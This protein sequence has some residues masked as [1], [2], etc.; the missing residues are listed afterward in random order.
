MRALRGLLNAGIA[1]AALFGPATAT[2]QPV[3]SGR[4]EV[5]PAPAA[6]TRHHAPPA[7][8][9]GAPPAAPPGAPPAATPPETHDA[10]QAPAQAQP[11]GH[12]AAP[13]RD[14]SLHGDK[15]TVRVTDVQ[16]EE[17]L[18]A[19][20]APSNAEIKGTVKESRTITIDFA[21]VP[22]QDGLGR[23]LGDQNFVLTY[24]EGGAL[25][26]ITLLGTP[27][28]ESAEARIVKNA[29]GTTTTTQPSLSPGEIMQRSVPIS[30]KL[31]Q[32]LGQPT[33]TMQQLMDISIHEE[34]AGLRTEAIRAGMQAID[35]APD[36]RSSVL[37]SLE[38]A[39]D[40]VLASMLRNVAQGRANEIIS[41]VAAT[42]RTP[43]IRTRGMQILRNL[44]APTE[45]AETQ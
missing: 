34:N 15:L 45:P 21:E 42:S 38:G 12:E 39:D 31:Q 18:K 9:P 13:P 37:K 4:Q 36:L 20:T 30:G 19:I 40:G 23:I 33:A 3:P 22:I 10:A 17:V 43:E 28:E 11:E 41:Q 35:N 1:A 32:V 24:R 2:A 14:I 25:K 8:P 16:V 7:A 5:A 29:A 26:A 6:P 27:L 44:N